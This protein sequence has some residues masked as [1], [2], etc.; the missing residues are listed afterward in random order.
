[1]IWRS[2]IR[3]TIFYKMIYLIS[4]PGHKHGAF[5]S[6]S[7]KLCISHFSNS[8]PPSFI[9]FENSSTIPIQTTQEVKDLGVYY[10]SK[11]SFSEHFSSCTKKAFRS[12]HLIKRSFSYIDKPSFQILYSSF[13]RPHLEFCSQ[14]TFSGLKQDINLLER[15][16][17]KA[18]KLV[19]HLKHLSTKIDSPILTY[20]L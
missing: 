1:M 16:Q 6:I 20:S 10:S 19:P 12:L 18:T 3:I 15:V 4:K 9:M 7:P 11:L 17:R 13:I 8:T 2:G 14:A 5:L